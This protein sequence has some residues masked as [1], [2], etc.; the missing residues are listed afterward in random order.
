VRKEWGLRGGFT[1]RR[2]YRAIVEWAGRS[3]LNLHAVCLG[4]GGVPANEPGQ[5]WSEVN[6]SCVESDRSQAACCTRRPCR[7]V[8]V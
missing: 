4:G 3:L 5:W 8:V 7:E 1:G 6:V 2:S